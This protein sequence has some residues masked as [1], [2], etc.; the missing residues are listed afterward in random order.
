MNATNRRHILSLI[1][2]NDLGKFKTVDSVLYT[3]KT[4]RFPGCSFNGCR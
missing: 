4:E 3:G 2:A 1:L